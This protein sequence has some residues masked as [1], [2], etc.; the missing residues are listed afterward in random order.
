MTK[1]SS[2]VEARVT[3]RAEPS[4]HENKNNN[5]LTLKFYLEID[6]RQLTGYEYV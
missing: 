1:S 4:Q 6:P 3:G 5:Y 2:L